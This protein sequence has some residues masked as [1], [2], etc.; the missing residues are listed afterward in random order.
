[1]KIAMSLQQQRF[2]APSLASADATR[3]GAWAAWL[4]W[5]Y[6]LALAFMACPYEDSVRDISAALSIAG[7]S[8]WPSMGPGLAFSAHL[9]PIWFYLLAQVAAFS[10]SWLGVALF[11]AAVAGLK[12]PLAYRLG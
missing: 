2:E 8:Q 4:L 5:L 12:F 10:S 6:A 7:G 9:G 3:I 1:M 11:V